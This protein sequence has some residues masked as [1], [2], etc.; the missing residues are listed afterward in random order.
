VT[1]DPQ[2]AG[3]Y[4]QVRLF[5]MFE[6]FGPSAPDPDNGHVYRRLTTSIPRAAQLLAWGMA[7][8]LIAIRRFRWDPQPG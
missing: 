2:V 4:A 8:G 7:G 5:D 1:G 3:A 6:A